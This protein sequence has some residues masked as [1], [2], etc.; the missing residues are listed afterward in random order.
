VLQCLAPSIIDTS[1]SY[2]TS[3]SLYYMTQ[4]CHITQVCPSI[5]WHKYVI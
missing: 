5:T 4:V 2:N 1:M 3:M